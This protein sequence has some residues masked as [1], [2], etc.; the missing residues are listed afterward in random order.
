MGILMDVRTKILAAA[1]LFAIVIAVYYPAIHTR[2]VADDFRIVGQIGFDDAIRSL[3]STVGY[4]RNEYRP[5]VAFS[6]ALS[7]ALWGGD[8]RGYHFESV[9]LHALNTG[10]LFYWLLL[11]TRSTS[12][13]GTAALLFAVHP[14]NHE[15]VVWIAARDSLLSTL[16]LLGAL[17]A[18]TLSRRGLHLFFRRRPGFGATALLVVSLALFCLSLLSYEGSVVIPA[19]VFGLEFFIFSRLEGNLRSRLRNAMIRVLPFVILLAAYLTFWMLLFRG[20]V[21]QYDLSSSAA[22]VGRNYYSLLYRLFFGHQ[23]L[24]GVIYFALILLVWHLPRDWRPLLVFSVLFMLV[25]FLPFTMIKGFAPRFAYTSALGYTL[26]LAV[27]L[28]AGVCGFHTGDRWRLHHIAV[29]STVMMFLVLGA[30]YA[31]A[32]RDRISDWRTAGEIAE[33]IP[34]QIKAH[35]PNLPDGSTL[36]LARIPRM[37]GRAYVYPLGLRTS[38]QGYYPGRSLNIFYGEGEVHEILSKNGITSRGAVLFRYQPEQRRIAEVD[39]FQNHCP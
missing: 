1:S 31:I 10:L 32:L 12:I 36:V 33:S 30:Y 14:L 4:G 24:A 16:F 3:S 6:F 13:S 37:Y 19:V 15:R 11:L 7:N 26:L 18:Y 2:K 38:I 34:Q 25:S 29:A 9:L 28:H 23:Y 39:S 35:Y 21:G 17:I 22:N 8:S 27:L 20:E 5:M